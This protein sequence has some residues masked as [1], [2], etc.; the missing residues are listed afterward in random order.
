MSVFIAMACLGNNIDVRLIFTVFVFLGYRGQRKKLNLVIKVCPSVCYQ[1]V[2]HERD[3]SLNCNNFICKIDI[4]IKIFMHF[5]IL[6]DQLFFL[7][8]STQKQCNGIV[9]SIDYLAFYSNNQP[10]PLRHS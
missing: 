3:I 6:F 10:V 1:V 7:Q 9:Q 5:R 8:I 2:L 4:L